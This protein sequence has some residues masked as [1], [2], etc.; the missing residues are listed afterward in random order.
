[1]DVLFSQLLV[2]GIA[3]AS[4]FALAGVSWGIIYK[5]TRTFHYSHQLVFSVAGYAAALVITQARLHF[6]FGLVV[7][8]LVAVILGCAI[9]GYLYRRLRAS[10][11]TQ[12]TIFLGSLGLTT[13]GIAIMLLVFSSNPRPLEGF[14]VIILSLGHANFTTADLMMVIVSW[15]LI[16]LLF[17]F[18]NKSSYGKAIRAVAS[19]AE[20][21]KN[22]GLNID[23]IYL[24]VFGIGSGLFGAGAFLFAAKNVAFPTMGGLPFFM[25][26]TA[27]FLG[28]V[29]SIPGAALAGFIL[30][31]AE[32][33]GMMLFPGEYK[34]MIV[35][36]ILFVVILIKPEGLLSSKR[37]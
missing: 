33:L 37:G 11:A 13:A 25:S 19:N 34:V 26:F 16:G 35:Y 7:S 17:L 22:I 12:T 21:A 5:T 23:H 29:N 1:M 15:V 18:L 27:V 6:I 30:G 20:M 24:L 32:N 2:N 3:T 31:I 9:E 14:P 4:L 8:I 28:G 36:A 10:G